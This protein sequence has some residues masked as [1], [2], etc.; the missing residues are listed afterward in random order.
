MSAVA[1][2]DR[3]EMKRLEAAVTELTAAF[4]DLPEDVTAELIRQEPMLGTLFMMFG[5]PLPA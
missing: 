3:P 2:E 4:K 5:L 1:I